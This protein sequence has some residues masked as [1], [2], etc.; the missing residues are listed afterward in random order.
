MSRQCIICGA[1]PGQNHK[2]V[3]LHFRR[4]AD[5][6]KETIMLS[7]LPVI[8]SHVL[9]TRNQNMYGVLSKEAERS[10]QETEIKTQELEEVILSVLKEASSY[11]IVDDFERRLQHEE[12]GEGSD[13]IREDTSPSADVRKRS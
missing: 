11:A 12:Q 10:D 9:H 1:F 2:P 4:Q 6:L 7:V 13:N 5:R 3:L 8:R